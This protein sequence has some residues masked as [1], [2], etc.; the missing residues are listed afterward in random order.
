MMPPLC[1]GSIPPSCAG[2]CLNSSVYLP[3][4]HS[5]S[6][7]PIRH[8]NNLLWDM[9]CAGNINQGSEQELECGDPKFYD[10]MSHEKTS[11]LRK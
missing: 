8:D 1:S 9:F 7:Y 6:S 4:S 2:S 3:A 11:L 10:Q 5:S